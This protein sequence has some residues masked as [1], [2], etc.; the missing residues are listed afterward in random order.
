MNPNLDEMQQIHQLVIARIQLS[1]HVLHDGFPDDSAC[2]YMRL[3]T[4]KNPKREDPRNW[5]EVLAGSVYGGT[6]WTEKWS[7]VY[8]APLV[9]S[10]WLNIMSDRMD[11]SNQL[12]GGLA[13]K[14]G[15][16]DALWVTE[17]DE[18]WVEAF[19]DPVFRGM[20]LMRSP[21]VAHSFLMSHP[22]G[23]KAFSPEDLLQCLVQTTN[24]RL[25]MSM[26]FK[27]FEDPTQCLRTLDLFHGSQ[28]SLYDLTGLE[29]HQL[30]VVAQHAPLLYIDGYLYQYD[31]SRPYPDN[32]MIR[33]ALS[34]VFESD[35]LR[36]LHHIQRS[37]R[38]VE[39]VLSFTQ[40]Q[41]VFLNYVPETLK[42][43]ISF[44]LSMDLP[45]SH[46]CQS[47]IRDNLYEDLKVEGSDT[48]L[49]GVDFN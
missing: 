41:S 28:G 20:C 33:L 39:K 30:L 45:L 15:S 5:M 8:P 46:V 47:L 13:L 10:D 18:K 9:Q 14:P 44:A 3:S 29:P 34:K 23:A 37:F 40:G 25:S 17:F 24:R 31:E 43:A 4:S 22:S 21:N 36:D 26:L 19:K 42:T 12:K 16:L 27:A 11:T 32:P 49:V 7:T 6:A 38:A 35:Y 1:Q 2:R 48:S